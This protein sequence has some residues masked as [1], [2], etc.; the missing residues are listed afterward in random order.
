MRGIGK[1]IALGVG[2]PIAAEE[3]G[4]MVVDALLPCPQLQWLKGKVWCWCGREGLAIEEIALH[5][6]PRR[7]GND[8]LGRRA[9]K[10]TLPIRASMA[11]AGRAKRS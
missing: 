10:L 5:D 9:L 6:Y 7:G 4:L 8:G 1:Q 2:W 3:W 11:S